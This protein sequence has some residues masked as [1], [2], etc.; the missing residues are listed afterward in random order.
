MSQLRI[1]GKPEDWTNWEKLIEQCNTYVEL[2][3]IEKE[4]AKCA[5]LFLKQEFGEEFL[6]KAFEELHPIMYYFVNSA[7]WTRKRLTRFADALTA[8]R[9]KEGYP[10]LL[11]RLKDKNRFLEGESVLEI[12]YKFS[13]A[14]FRIIIDPSTSV[15]RKVPDLK[16]KNEENGEELFVEVSVQHQS[17]NHTKAIRTFDEFFNQLSPFY[18]L[19]YCGRIFKILNERHI[20]E[21]LEMVRDKIEAAKKE[22]AFQELMIEDTIELGIAPYKDND[23]LAAWAKSR[24]LELGRFTGPPFNVDEIPR[25]RMKIEREQ[26]QLPQNSPNILVIENNNLFRSARD[27]KREI[28]ELEEC[29]YDFSNLLCFIGI[30]F[31]ESYDKTI[32]DELVKKNQHIVIKKLREDSIIEQCMIL[33]NR[34]CD[35]EVTSATIDKIYIAFS[36][37]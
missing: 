35:F 34:F 18:G 13:K 27:V 20:T 25:T 12:A 26:L 1:S 17:M 33:R 31:F 7:P 30:G 23:V 22:N 36:K 16:I 4:K 21:I 28:S 2:T 15:N 14:S 8:L 6:K 29:L 10:S 5:L 24:G 9:T 11:E 37:C 3:D 19:T 32:Q